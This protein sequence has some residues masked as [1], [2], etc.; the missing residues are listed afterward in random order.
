MYK[1]LLLVLLIA[2]SVMGF[3]P[4]PAFRT[5]GRYIIVGQLS[6]LQPLPVTA[7]QSLFPIMDQIDSFKKRKNFVIHVLICTFLLLDSA[8]LIFRWDRDLK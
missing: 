2:V 6:S 8:L 5:A 4:S 1:S 3:A 7:L